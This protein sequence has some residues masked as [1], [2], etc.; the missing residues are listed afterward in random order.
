MVV[1]C[2]IF[3]LALGIGTAL[4]P[5][6]Q[7]PA[8]IAVVAAPPVPNRIPVRRL[9]DIATADS[10]VVD[11]KF[12]A[13]R[14]LYESIKNS[15]T[16]RASADF[17]LRIALCHEELGQFSAASDL[18]STVFDTG[19]PAQ[20]AL[21]RF[22][23]AR[24]AFRQGEMSA[25]EQELRKLVR[26]SAP[27]P[28][29]AVAD[30]AALY[31]ITLAELVRDP[32][33]TK[34]LDLAPNPIAW[35]PG[36]VL[37]WINA[38]AGDPVAHPPGIVLEPKRSTF[39]ADALHPANRIPAPLWLS[40]RVSLTSSGEAARDV[41]EHVAGLGGITL[42]HAGRDDNPGA[43]WSATDLPVSLIVAVL[44]HDSGVAWE[45]NLT[46]GVL[47]LSP[48]PGESAAQRREACRLLEDV[49]SED[50]PSHFSENVEF[51]LAELQAQEGS[52]SDAASRFRARIGKT[53]SELSLRSA[54]NAAQL[55]HRAG[56]LA[57]TAR[58]LERI[59]H[60]APGEDLQ[61]RALLMYGRTLLEQ[62]EF[63]EAAFQLR[64]AT[65]PPVPESLQA[66]AAVFL[67]LSQLLGGQPREAA[68]SLFANRMK[69]ADGPVR[70]AA[71]LITALA[72][73]R[74][75]EG[76]AQAKEATFLYRGIVAVEAER[77][78][79][80]PM[81]AVLLGQ[82]M[83]A[84]ELDQGMVELYA[85]SLARGVCPKARRLMQ[86]GL[87]DF[88]YR[89]GDRD[90]AIALWTEVESEGQ[91]ESLTAGLRLAEAALDDRRPG[92]CLER[93]HLLQ[94]R[95][96]APRR[97]LQRLAGRAYEQA[98]ETVRAAQCY[99]GTWPLP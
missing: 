45:L 84:A 63:R 33:I 47:E 96:Q 6:P 7:P 74:T 10:L 98:G 9:P 37:S 66:R 48:A 92:Q 24:L 61:A 13:A 46:D 71:S 94:H 53:S 56:D 17:S 88:W 2:A 23:L 89:K 38:P 97:E 22:G 19:T 12:E 69:F 26:N 83:D 32:A 4:Q 3:P 73:W 90:R 91:L 5:V 72:R 70:H 87:A 16:L 57:A 76:S 60:G 78:W 31:A 79:L 82:A 36:R 18:Y 58:S 80:G 59:V 86:L 15:G 14:L 40:T 50:S 54:W 64:R 34:D 30:A 77:D 27:L 8:E 39:E 68:E 93:C 29:A 20:Q 62:G 28:D 44:A 55:F 25:A 43:P 1:L 49:R 42:R 51:A 41:L 81:G 85:A 67:G 52:I 35:A 95:D 65:N 75:T 21:A 99:A 11:Q